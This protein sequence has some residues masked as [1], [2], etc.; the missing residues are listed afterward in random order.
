MML[1]G[2]QRGANGHEILLVYDQECPV[3]DAYCRS[4]H[5]RE[6][7]GELRL[8]NA[9]EDTAFMADITRLGLDIDQ[10]MVVV[11]GGTLHYGADAIHALAR[12]SSASSVFGRINYWLFTSQSRSQR[13]Y[14]LLRSAR[15]LLL[16][17]LGKTKINNLQLP[18]HGRF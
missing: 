18:D 14:P 9:R 2:G 7:A 3:C 8:I 10:G 15:N 4:L 17:A 16:K 13:L 1:R 5:I 12:L 11:A 6:S